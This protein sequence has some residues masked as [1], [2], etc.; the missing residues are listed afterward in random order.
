M[1][2]QGEHQLSADSL[3][4]ET[5]DVL[6]V[7]AGPAGSTAALHLAKSGHRVLLLDRAQFPREKICGDGLISD[8]INCLQRAGLIDVVRRVGHA[9]G[10]IT[11][12]SPSRVE[13]SVKGEFITLKRRALD[14]LIARKAATNGAVFCRGK[15]K[16]LG[17]EPDGTVTATLAS[18]GRTLRARVGIVATGVRLDLLLKHDM[19]QKV[20]HD[21]VALRCY[22]RSTYEL[23]RMIVSWDRSITPGYAW[24]FPMGNGEYNVGCGFSYRYKKKNTPSLHEFFRIFTEQFPIAR[25]LMNKSKMVSPMRGAT[26]RW[27]LKGIN[28]VGPGNLLAI[29]ETIATTYQMTGEGIGKAMESGEIAAE[30]IH[31]ALESNDFSKLSQ[32]PERLKKEL[33]PRYLGYK[34]GERWLARPW[35]ADFLARRAQKSKFLR[36]SMAGI[37]TETVDPRTIFSVKG[38]LKSFFS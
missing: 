7:G 17:V 2:D 1:P 31:Q 21:A 15:V 28:P 20:K 16:Q 23:N 9:V 37:I 24:I 27:G 4:D 34:I 3:P 32:Y 10:E 6:I 38:V 18:G 19:V 26:L 35:L 11:T 25:D 5:F 29:G 36:D 33:E 13:L 22:V 12:F 8:S 14:D 30:I